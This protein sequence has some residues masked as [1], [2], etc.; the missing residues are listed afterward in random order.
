MSFRRHLDVTKCHKNVNLLNGSFVSGHQ[1]GTRRSRIIVDDTRPV[2]LDSGTRSNTGTIER[3]LLDDRGRGLA[4]VAAYLTLE[5][6]V[7]ETGRWKRI[8]RI[9]KES[10]SARSHRP[11]SDL[12]EIR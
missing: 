8:V 6:G 7:S 5:H 11:H 12:F 1:S 2:H 10:R 4:K 9:L 3:P